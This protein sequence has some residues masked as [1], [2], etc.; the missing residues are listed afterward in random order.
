MGKPDWTRDE[1]ILALDLYFREP[2]ARGSKAHPAVKELSVTL[3]RLASHLGTRVDPDFRNPNG[4]GMKLANYLRFDPMYTGKGLTRGSRL[5]EEVWRIYG[6]DHDK[7]SAV[8]LAIRENIVNGLSIEEDSDDSDEYEAEEGRLLSRVHQSRERDRG[9]VKRKKAQAL[10]VTG[11]MACEACGFDYH[12]AYGIHGKGFA[13]CH[14][15]LPLSKLRPGQKTR[16]EDL[17]ILCASCHR[18]IHRRPDW[19]SMKDLRALL[20]ESKH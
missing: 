2:S 15:I 14:H 6:S 10:E 19:L 12:A 7:L 13:E 4:V 16:L 11:Q 20:S 8:A 3:N 9:I 18:M 17:V 5:E 1:L